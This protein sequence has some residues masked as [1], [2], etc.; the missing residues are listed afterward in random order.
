MHVLQFLFLLN[1]DN[2]STFLMTLVR[3]KSAFINCWV[4]LGKSHSWLILGLS[5]FIYTLCIIFDNRFLRDLL[6][7]YFVYF[8]HQWS[9]LFFPNGVLYSSPQKCSGYAQK[10]SNWSSPLVPTVSLVPKPQGYWNTSWI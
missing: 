7:S 6:F 8:Y 3:S 1:G 5:F 10:L 2:Y 9:T 4:T